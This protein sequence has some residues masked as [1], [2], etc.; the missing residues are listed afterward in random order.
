MNASTNGDIIT[1]QEDINLNEYTV[2]RSTEAAIEGTFLTIPADLSVTFDLN[3]HTLS[4]K[5]SGTGKNQVLFDVRGN[6]TVKN[7][8]MTIE[9][10]A[11]KNLGW[12]YCTEIFYVGFDGTLNVV[13]ATL[14]NLGGS[15][16]AYCVDL[17]NAKNT[18]LNIDDS[19]VE[20]TY[21]AVRVFNN[22]NGM[23]HVAINNSTIKGSSRA[24][25]VHMYTEADNKGT[26]KDYTLDLD[27]FGN[28]NTYVGSEKRTI[29]F[30]FTNQITFDG[31]GEL[32]T[33][34]IGDDVYDVIKTADAL[35]EA[36]SNGPSTLWVSGNLEGTFDVKRV[37]AINSV[38]GQ[39]TIT[40]RVN[41]YTDAHGTS[42]KN[43]NFDINDYSKV[44]N[45]FTG[46]NYQ[47][48]AIV[49]INCAAVSFDGCDFKTNINK[50]V[51]AINYGNHASNVSDQILT[52][53]DCNFEGDF[54]AI[55][56]R[57]FFNITDSHFKSTY[58][59]DGLSCVW[60]WGNGDSSNGSVTF[61]R[62]T[63][64]SNY[65]YGALQLTASNY[66]Y[67]NITFNVKD[68]VGYSD[69]YWTNPNRTYKNIT[70]VDGSETFG[71][72]V[73]STQ[74]LKAALDE[75]AKYVDVAAGT[76]TFPASYIKEGTTINCEEGTVFEGKSSLNIKGATVVGAT[77]KNDGDQAVS[78]TIYGTFKNCTFEGQ[79]TLRWCYTKAGEQTVFENCVVKTSLRGIHFDEMN[80]DVTFRNCEINGFN[81]YSGTGSITFEGCTFGHDKSKY[82]GLNIYSNT[83]LKNCEFN[84]VS[85]NTNFIDMEGTG[86]TLTIENCTAT[87]D[88]AAAEISD[89]VGG[90]K[91]SEN[92]VVYK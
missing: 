15:S 19:N 50:S 14:K 35:K 42:F 27:I 68:N 18:T 89:F 30:G 33:Y 23:N 76:Y 84:Y 78:G 17:V 81:A 83:S 10:D 47:Y 69:T 80:G 82:N 59:A 44:A 74:S 12:N 57:P 75:G 71:V 53:K 48:P 64:E 11:D 41:V 87:L 61:Q 7:G 21:V 32:V 49:V 63:A 25:W 29:E 92:T 39:A 16:M 91:L 3:G 13:D 24:F 45:S 46:A 37:V 22:S 79:E 43:I 77:F 72:P 28:G 26:V 1:L 85:G 34:A 5:T 36:I 38:K 8:T 20:S 66:V 52:V 6:L 31:E 40:G 73:T 90:S 88:G 51:G 62:N 55:R 56:T 9:H 54:Y 67:Q 58:P 60:V 4:G 70:F 86:K 65:V 2:T